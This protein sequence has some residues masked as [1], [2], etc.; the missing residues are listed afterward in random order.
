[1]FHPEYGLGVFLIEL[2]EIGVV[3][4]KEVAALHEGLGLLLS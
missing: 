3:R 1:M 2:G 4:G